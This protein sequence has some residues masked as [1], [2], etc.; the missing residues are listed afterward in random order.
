MGK[1]EIIYRESQVVIVLTLRT[2][3]VNRVVRLTLTLSQHLRTQGA[4]AHCHI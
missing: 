3:P 1:P 2:Q 4:V